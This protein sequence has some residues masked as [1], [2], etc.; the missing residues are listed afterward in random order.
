MAAPAKRRRTGGAVEGHEISSSTTSTQDWGGEAN[1]LEHHSFGSSAPLA[2]EWQDVRI[3]SLPPTWFLNARVLEIGCGSGVQC[4]LAAEAFRPTAILGVDIDAGLI[5]RARQLLTQ[6]AILHSARLPA[7]VPL[8]QRSLLGLREPMPAVGSDGSDVIGVPP[9]NQWDSRV[10]FRH[11]D[12]IAGE[13]D[14]PQN[15]YDLIILWNVTKWVQL[16]LGDEGVFK[17][18]RR[19]FHV[20]KPGGRLLLQAQPWSSYRRST[21]AAT[22]DTATLRSIN[23]RPDS[24]P[25]F[26]L[27]RVGFRELECVLHPRDAAAGGGKAHLPI[28]SFRK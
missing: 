11:E 18:F 7:N 22:S 14:H 26:L 17:L 13:I 24:F 16:N 12:F 5:A 15:A 28:Q 8:S 19:C 27:D 10:K 20:L 1:L 3:A 9:S 25:A 4:I 2:E 6:R 21:M 23:L